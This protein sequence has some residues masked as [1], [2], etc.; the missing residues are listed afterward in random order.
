M[1]QSLEQMAEQVLKLPRE[2]RAFLAERLLDSL[3]EAE[4]F[5]V[6]EA[7]RNEVKRR[8]KEIESGAVT[9]LPAE[10][11][12]ANLEEELKQCRSNSTR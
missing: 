9:S 3:D 8:A 11:V 7:W 6:S 5:T 1:T 12:F 2:S 10:E 4:D